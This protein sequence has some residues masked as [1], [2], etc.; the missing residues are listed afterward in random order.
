MSDKTFLQNSQPNHQDQLRQYTLTMYGLYAVSIIVGF[1]SIIAIA[2]NYIKRNDAKDTW[3]ASH[4]EWQLKTFWI[5]FIGSVIG[6]LLFSL[7]IGIPILFAVWI[8]FIYRIMKGLVVFMDNKPIGN[9]C[10]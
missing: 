3:L 9:G 1:F 10:F 8:W 7:L 6:I 5:T 2:M 4:F